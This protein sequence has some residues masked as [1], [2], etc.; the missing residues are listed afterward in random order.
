MNDSVKK[1]A[2]TRAVIYWKPE[3]SR[4][5]PAIV[6]YSL[7]REKDIRDNN[8]LPGQRDLYRRIMKNLRGRFSCF[9]ICFSHKG[10]KGAEIA[11]YDEHGAEIIRKEKE[12]DDIPASAERRPE[13]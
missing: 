7:D 10:E 5:Y 6:R 13:A 9:L 11:M 8:H 4:G 1:K 12:E 2:L 3:Y